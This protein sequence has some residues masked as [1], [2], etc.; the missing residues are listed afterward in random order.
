MLSACEYSNASAQTGG[1]GR[2]E[3]LE[4]SLT[5]RK[6]RE[7]THF[8][9]RGLYPDKKIDLIRDE[10][11]ANLI[12]LVADFGE[13]D[14]NLSKTFLGFENGNFR[15]GGRLSHY[16]KDRLNSVSRRTERM[17]DE[18]AEKIK[19]VKHRDV[20]ENLLNIF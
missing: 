20:F 4:Y 13:Y 1:L 12:G 16:E 14:T 2:D 11:L 19:G 7:L 17:I 9:C 8:V 18:F 10:V 3:W 5:I 6:Y 15:E